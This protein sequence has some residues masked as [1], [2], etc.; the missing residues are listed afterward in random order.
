VVQALERGIGV[1]EI[2]EHMVERPVLQGEDD[3]VLDGGHG[4]SLMDGQDAGTRR[5]R[6]AR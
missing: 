1:I 6:V 4:R 3:D 2:A 5:V